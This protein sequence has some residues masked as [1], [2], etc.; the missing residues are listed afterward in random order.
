MLEVAKAI[1]FLLTILSLYP[2]LLAAFFEPNTDW[3]QRM[4]SAAL[5]LLIA[6]CV[7]IISGL[8]FTWPAKSNPD[9]KTMLIQ[10]L[11]LKVFLSAA[12][13]ITLLFFAG[14]YTRCGAA[15]T[16]FHVRRDC[17]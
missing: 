16:S 5:R 14:W 6:A 1:S 10:T 3:Q 8:I 9:A 7:A 2:V 4:T 12:G 15:A 13:F 17:F 11:P